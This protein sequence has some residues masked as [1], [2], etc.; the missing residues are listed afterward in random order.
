MSP[1]ASTSFSRLCRAFSNSAR[2]V[3]SSS[4]ARFCVP[5]SS[6]RNRSSIRSFFRASNDA[7]TRSRSTPSCALRSSSS[8]SRSSRSAASVCSISSTAR[9]R[10]SSS[11]ATL[12]SR[13]WNSASVCS[14][15][16]FSSRH[17]RFTPALVASSLRNARPLAP[18]G[19]ATPDLASPL[20]AA[21]EDACELFFPDAAASIAF[22]VISS[23]L[24]TAFSISCINR[25]WRFLSSLYLVSMRPISFFIAPTT[26]P[27]T[28][29]S[30]AACVSFSS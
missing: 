17:A 5:I 7:R 9:A 26:S 22:V 27:P 12:R 4:C 3:S 20:A 14:M 10:S 2:T 25:S 30:S 29:G 28:S 16:F 15:L 8:R 11:S 18:M 21:D 13:V 6:S 1:M 24:Y 23:R 19:G